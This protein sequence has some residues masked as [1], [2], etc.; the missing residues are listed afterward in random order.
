MADTIGMM[1]PLY[2]V[3]KNDIL[4]WVNETLHV[5]II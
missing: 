1:N 4:K 5:T 3:T 2:T